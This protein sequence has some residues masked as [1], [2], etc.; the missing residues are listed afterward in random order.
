MVVPVFQFPAPSLYQSATRTKILATFRIL[1]G[2]KSHF[3]QPKA[4]RHLGTQWKRNSYFY[5][6][7]PFSGFAKHV[8]ELIVERAQP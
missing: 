2:F 7:S 8:G 6:H 5:C 1:D 3:Q 4:L